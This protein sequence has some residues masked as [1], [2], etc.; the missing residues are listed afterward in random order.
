MLP[1][2]DKPLPTLFARDDAP[3]VLVI[4]PA[5]IGDALMAQSLFKVLKR[6]QAHLNIDVLAPAW[7]AGLLKRMPEVRH[8]FTHT[9]EHGQLAWQERYRLGKNLR[10]YRYQQAI[11]LPNSWKSA[12]IPFW[13][14]IPQRTGYIGEMRYGL[15]NDRRPLDT[16]AL[17]RTVE[18]FV[19]LG[20]PKNDPRMGKWLPQPRLLA[21]NVELTC[22]SAIAASIGVMSG[23]GVWSG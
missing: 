21:G 5:W 18:Q 17:R 10:R 1:F 2:F 22:S 20:L 15:L 3:A 7:S 8:I 23:G 9:I 11:V 4:A 16:I 14:R 12:L 6:Q 19:A 13:A